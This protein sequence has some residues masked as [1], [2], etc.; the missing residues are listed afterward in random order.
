MFQDLNENDLVFMIEGKYYESTS[1][2][3]FVGMLDHGSNNGLFG[4]PWL[5]GKFI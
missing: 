2:L 1:E 4:L 5:D 3:V